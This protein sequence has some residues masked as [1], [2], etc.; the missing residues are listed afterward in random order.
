[1]AE[2]NNELSIKSEI[3]LLEKQLKE[4]KLALENASFEKKDSEITKENVKENE[5]LN[6]QPATTQAKTAYTD[7]KDKET[8]VFLD[9]KKLKDL[10]VSRQVRILTTLAFEKGILYSIKV[11]RKLN[12]PY[13]LDELHDKLVGELHDELVKKG[14]LKEV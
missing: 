1:M 14:K 3:E 6:V 13:L 11:A 2:T 12:D 7:D 10:D 4:K 5:A 9:A 8:E